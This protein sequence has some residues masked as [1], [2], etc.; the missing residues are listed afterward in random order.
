MIVLQYQWRL[1]DIFLS[2]TNL[3]SKYCTLLLHRPS[4]QLSGQS[5]GTTQF[6]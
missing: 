5:T 1:S 2:H 6:S 3:P 4:C